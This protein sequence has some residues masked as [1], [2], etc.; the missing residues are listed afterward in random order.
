M[1][2]VYLSATLWSAAF[3]VY[4]IAYAPRLA[5]PRLDGRPG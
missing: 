1:P 4:F 5:R 3:L 2:L